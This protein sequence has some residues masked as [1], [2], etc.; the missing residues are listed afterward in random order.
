[1]AR[2]STYLNF[3]RTTEEAFTF[4]RSVFGTE[5]LGPIARF[6]DMPGCADQPPL[7][8]ADKRL[9]MHVKLPILAGHVLMGTDAPE[10]MGFKV[11]PGNNVFINLE[12]DTRDETRRLFDAL[13]A[14]GKV[15][16]PLQEMFWGGY[17]GSLAD[18]YGVRWMFNCASKS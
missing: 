16:M 1:M 2:V 17:F 14:G 7:A 10:S 9:V 18:R 3:P 4:Y 8:E 12:P 11:A 13:A 15:E 5:F 6:G